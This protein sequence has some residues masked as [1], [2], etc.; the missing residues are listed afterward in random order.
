MLKKANRINTTRELQKVYRGGKTL[1]T[2]ALVVKF[3]AKLKT[4]IGFVISKKVSKQ[5]VTRNRIKRVLREFMRVS[6]KKIQPGDY[7]IVVK[8]GADK[9]ETF[10]IREQLEKSLK[11]SGLWQE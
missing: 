10:L 3:V 5:A 1:H 2:P 4:R 6:I 8:P 9:Y 7:M 11:R